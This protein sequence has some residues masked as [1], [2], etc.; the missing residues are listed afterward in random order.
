[1]LDGFSGLGE[2]K[3]A[4]VQVQGMEVGDGAGMEEVVSDAAASFTLYIN[5]KVE[6]LF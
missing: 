4:V 3:E 2:A 5:A 1:M 6:Y